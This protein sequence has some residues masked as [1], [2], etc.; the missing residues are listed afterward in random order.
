MAN[1]TSV[2]LTAGVPT[3]GTGTVSTIDNMPNLV[4]NTTISN[5]ANTAA[6]K[7]ASTAPAT[8]DPALVVAISPNS[9]N[10][11]GLATQANSTPVVVAPSTVA[12]AVTPTVTAGSY[13]ANYCIGGILTFSNLLSSVSFSG[14]LESITV[15][16]KGTAVT[17]NIY[18][19]L[20]KISP[21]NGTYTDHTAVT[22]NAADAVNLLGTYALTT[23]SSEL[24]TMA[25]YNL[26]AVGKAIQ[27]TSASLYAVV[28]V[29]G[30]PDPASSS[31]MTV[32]LA[33]LQG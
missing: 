22:W 28:Q 6:V 8:T 21:S 26:D 33:V 25:V 15:K 14:I 10:A 2:T 13:T 24:G 32:E 3:A 20:F 23:V 5:G 19:S 7:A 18:V 4:M 1:L 27:G 11:N 17:G 30:T 9:Q 31:D 12:V 29:G 16:F